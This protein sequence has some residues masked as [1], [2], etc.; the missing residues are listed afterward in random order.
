MDGYDLSL[1][2]EIRGFRSDGEYRRFLQFIEECL[3]GGRLIE[4]PVDPE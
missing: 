3:A 1:S 4:V 2:E